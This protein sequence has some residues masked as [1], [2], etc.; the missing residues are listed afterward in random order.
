MSAAYISGTVLCRRSSRFGVRRAVAIAGVLT[1]VGGTL[2]C[3]RCSA[4]TR[5]G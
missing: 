5:I 3:W 1:L 4:C 2:G